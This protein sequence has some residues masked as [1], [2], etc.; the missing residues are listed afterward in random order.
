VRRNVLG[1]EVD[2]AIAREDRHL[3]WTGGVRRLCV[4]P[5]DD[6]I[7]MIV[8]PKRGRGSFKSGRTIRS[9][10]W[11]DSAGF[12]VRNVYAEPG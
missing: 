7:D 1:I 11:L 2:K 12:D 9:A 8:R 10:R 6:H 4:N 5:N 3:T